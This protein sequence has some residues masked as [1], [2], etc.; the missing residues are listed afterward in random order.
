[1]APLAGGIVSA[2]VTLKNIR[3]DRDA[4]QS[5]SY[6]G[7][8]VRFRGHDEQALLEVLVDLEYEFL[9]DLLSGLPSPTILDIGAHIG[10]FAIWVFGVNENAHVLSLEADPKTHLVAE[11]N[12][13]TFAEGGVDWRL[14]QG[15]AGSEDGV[16]LRLSDTGP[17]MSHHVDP[18]GRIEV[19][20]MSLTTLLDRIAPGGESV[21]LVKIDIEGSEEAFLCAKPEALKRVNTLVIEL[22]PQLCDTA[23]VLSVLKGFFNHIEDIGCRRST[24]PLLYCRNNMPPREG[25]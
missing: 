12:V 25:Y 20:G 15:A 17:S 9:A 23:C 3:K 18:K 7:T 5:V 16:V 14:I 10:T 13:A 11:L 19:Q 24:K 4:I 1:M 2:I 22:H 8:P 6:R 21:D